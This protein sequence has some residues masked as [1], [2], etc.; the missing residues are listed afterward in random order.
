MTILGKKTTTVMILVRLL[1][2]MSTCI[3]MS[4]LKINISA[5]ITFLKVEI[6]SYPLY[7]C[8]VKNIGSTEAKQILPQILTFKKLLKG[9]SLIKYWRF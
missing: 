8:I 4:S 3:T 1:K 7:T 6:Q 9:L 5:E 2:M